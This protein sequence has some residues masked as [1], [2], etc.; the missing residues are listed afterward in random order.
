MNT[1]MIVIDGMPKMAAKINE[2]RHLSEKKKT[3]LEQTFHKPYERHVQSD[4]HGYYE[5]TF[6]DIPS[7]ACPSHIIESLDDAFRL[8]S[9]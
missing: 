4:H 7:I 5:G 1:S 6:S 3:R 8:T 9:M 2:F